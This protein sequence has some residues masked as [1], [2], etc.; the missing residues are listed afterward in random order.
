MKKQ[1]I[2]TIIEGN[3]EHGFP[4]TLEIKKDEYPF[5]VIFSN[6]GKLPS[7]VNP[8]IQKYLQ[9]WQSDYTKWVKSMKSST[10]NNPRIK[11]DGTG[12][13]KFN[14]ESAKNLALKFNQWLESLE[15][16]WQEKIL[17]PLRVNLNE[18]DEIRLIIR[19][20]NPDLR[21]LPW[22]AWKLFEKEY[23]NAE[24]SL[25]AS[26]VKVPKIKLN[27]SDNSLVK[28]LAVFGN[29][30]GIDTNFDQEVLTKLKGRN[31]HITFLEQPTKIRLLNYLRQETGWDIFFFAGHSSTLANGEIGKLEINE[32]ES[33]SID[34]LKN[35]MKEAIAQGLQLA[36]FNSC[37]GLGLANQLAKLYLPQSIVMR[38]IVPDAVAQQFLEDFLTDFSNNKS[39]YMSV[40]NARG[41]LEDAKNQEFPGISW[42]PIICQ[43]TTVQPP[44]WESL[45]KK[46]TTPSDFNSRTW[47]CRHTLTNH[48]D[49]IKSIAIHPNGEIFASC[50]IDRTIK[51]W[52]I[53]TGELLHNISGYSS[54]VTCITFSNNGKILASSSA[55]P[56]ATIKLWD[57]QTWQVK[58]TLRS[59][60]WGLLNFLTIWSIAMSADGKTIVSG[61]NFDSTVKVWNAETGEIRHTLR[62]HPWAVMSV[63]I[64]PSGQT[65][66]SG[67]CNSNIKVWNTNTGKELLNLNGFDEDL[68]G[69]TRSFLDD[70]Y[71]YSLAFS[72][73]GRTLASGG[74]KQ[75]I[76]LWNL[77]SGEINSN[78]TAHTDYVYTVAFS[79]DGKYLASGGS[80][81]TI[82][83][84]D[85][86]KAEPIDTLGHDDM[87]KTLAFSR[88]G[89]TL[90]SGGKDRIIK[91]WQL[92]A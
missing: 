5:Q 39:L 76:N 71:V 51:I 28:I 10:K 85:L 63:A 13:T 29:S 78:L 57:T 8:N 79:P 31:A 30:E 53:N 1:V 11:K 87:V 27:S 41:K 58:R 65:I 72:P 43:N 40:R 73:D 61:H 47:K 22:S 62:G 4:L 54:G 89:C 37:D 86:S 80:D 56:D 7:A 17:N 14:D 9:Q 2:L 20:D 6:V 34:D 88:D 67:G 52:N 38:E 84:W 32:N 15:E 59:Y 18:D 45:L 83:I 26:T 16:L 55:Y 35:A 46:T 44:T 24:I 82:R 48:S 36:I 42:L 77:N 74:Y 21:R 75:P 92:S 81:R 49:M 3:F 70:N 23:K 60:D 50:S 19:T 66:A 64:A 12:G 25:A 68:V 90:I 91:I 33:L 69:L